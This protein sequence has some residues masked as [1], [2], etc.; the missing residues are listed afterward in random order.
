MQ[1]EMQTIA[2]TREGN[3]A[4]LWREEKGALRQPRWGFLAATRID[5]LA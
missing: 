3:D 5:A 1:N 2:R 4:L